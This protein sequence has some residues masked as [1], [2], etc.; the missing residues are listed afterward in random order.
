MRGDG[1]SHSPSVP[2]RSRGRFHFCSTCRFSNLPLSVLLLH[3]L[4]CNHNCSIN[5]KNGSKPAHLH[6]RIHCAHFLA[7][8]KR[9]VPNPPSYDPVMPECFSRACRKQRFR[10]ARQR[11]S[12]AELMLFDRAILFLYFLKGLQPN[13]F[14]TEARKGLHRQKRGFSVLEE[15]VPKSAILATA[16]RFYDRRRVCI[17]DRRSRRKTGHFS[18]QYKLPRTRRHTDYSS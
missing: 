4:L 1:S 9:A 12:G 8:K 3:R 17:R 10:D 14:W 7:L 15:S 11:L 13:G 6:N 18:P 2:G 16:V 5:Q